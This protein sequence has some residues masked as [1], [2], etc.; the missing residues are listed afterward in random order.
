MKKP[1]FDTPTHEYTWEHVLTYIH[2]HSVHISAMSL[3]FACLVGLGW[4]GFRFLNTGFLCLTALA[5]LELSL[6]TRL[7]SNSERSA[8]L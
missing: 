7:A 3:L 6:E 8:C 5:V 2:T 1:L 4:V